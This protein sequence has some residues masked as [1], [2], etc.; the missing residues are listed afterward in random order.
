MTV[1]DLKDLPKDIFALFN[2]KEDHIINE[3]N[4]NEFAENLK[5]VLRDRFKARPNVDYALRFSSMGRPDRQVWFDAHPD[6]A[7]TEKMSPKTLYKFLYG[8]ILEQLLLFLAKEAGHE[9]TNHQEQVEVDGVKGHIDAIIDGTVVDVKSAS[10]FGYKKFAEQRVTE[11]DPFGY[12]AQLAGYAS[13]LTPGKPAAWLAND[14]V[15]GDICISPLS[16]MVIKH[17]PPAERISHLKEVITSETPPELC[18]EPVPDGKS[19][20]LK[21]GIGCSY[22]RHKYR[23]HP[24]LRTFL[25]STGPRFLT[26]VVREPDVPEV[27][28]EMGM[29]TDAED[30]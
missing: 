27:A 19:G 24:G 17:Y 11:E 25:Y 26:K 12:V 28:K 2:E 15:H 3:D 10:P 21:L 30:S 23:C 20:N 16:D 13:V 6:P 8:D 1:P 5:Q 18:Y 29:V 4:L 14:K 9:V 7:L 22:C